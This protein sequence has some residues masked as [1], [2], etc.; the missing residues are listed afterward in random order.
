MAQRTNRLTAISLKRPMAPGRYADGNNLYLEVGPSG[1]KRWALIY[2]HQSRRRELGLGTVELVS[3]A[4]AR[5]RAVEAAQLRQNGLDPKTVWKVQFAPAAPMT[6][7]AVALQ[8]ISDKKGGWSNVKSAAQWESSLRTYAKG[9]WAK[10]VADIDVE[11]V[12]HILRPIWLAKP[13]TASRVRGRVQAV[14]D[15]AKVRKLRIGEN[16]AIWAGNLSHILATQPSGPKRHQPSMPYADVPA[17]M[18]VLRSRGEFSARALELTI[19]TACRT[20]EVREALWE[21]IDLEAGVLA[22]PAA[23]MKM[24]HAHRVALSSQAIDILRNVGTT[25]GLVFPGQR[26]GKP[27]SNMTMQ[28]LLRRLGLRH[29]TVHGFRSSFSTWAA[30]ATEF[31]RDLVEL[32]LAHLVGSDVERAY[33]RSDSL[34]KRAALMQAWGDEISRN[35]DGRG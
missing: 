35:G 9:I 2:T 4:D 15:A 33:R 3:L 21:E 8:V 29:F 31:P 7:G 25:T 12:L 20:S 32:S 22:I 16:P 1:S 18:K 13:E 6:F 11:D 30:E 28:Q 24:R 23:R 26:V 19:L 10:P 27:I 5:R 14:L 34:L 17:F